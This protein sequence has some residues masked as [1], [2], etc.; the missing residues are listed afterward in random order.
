MSGRKEGNAEKVNEGEKDGYEFRE[1]KNMKCD[2][3][4]KGIECEEEIH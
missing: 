4:E 1:E 3:K 2:M